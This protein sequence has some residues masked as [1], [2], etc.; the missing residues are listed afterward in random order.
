MSSGDGHPDAVTDP[1]ERH[2]LGICTPEFCVVHRES[3]DANVRATVNL[4]KMSLIRDLV[5]ALRS[6]QASTDSINELTVRAQE[7]KCYP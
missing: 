4:K 6:G 1:Y 3:V 7:L 5:Y 2:R